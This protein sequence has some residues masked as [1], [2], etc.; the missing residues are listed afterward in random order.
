MMKALL[1]RLVSSSLTDCSVPWSG[2]LGESLGGAGSWCE[3][4]RVTT[5]SPWGSP[6]SMSGSLTSFLTLGTGELSS[7]LVLGPGEGCSLVGTG[8]GTGIGTGMGIKMGRGSIRVGGGRRGRP[9]AG[10]GIG[11]GASSTGGLGARGKGGLGLGRLGS[12]EWR[13]DLGLSLEADILR[14]WSGFTLSLG[15]F[16]TGETGEA[17][18]EADGWPGCLRSACLYTC[19]LCREKHWSPQNTDSPLSGLEMWTL[20]SPPHSPSHHPHL[21]TCLLSQIYTFSSALTF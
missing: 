1:F 19:L 8:I 21:D 2:R 4:L 14:R 15:L 16:D 6:S 9:G 3:R 18:V 17:E 12:R 11:G 20:E 7:L 10:A 5:L 13:A